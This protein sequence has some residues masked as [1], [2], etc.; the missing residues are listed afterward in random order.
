MSANFDTIIKANLLVLFAALGTISCDQKDRPADSPR[1]SSAR[2]ELSILTWSDYLVPEVV[3]RFES[4]SG[5]TVRVTEV[6]NSERLIQV[7]A[8]KPGS[9]DVIIADNDSVSKLKELSLI[10]SINHELVPEFERIAPEFRNLWFDPKNQFSVPYLWGATGIAYRKSAVPGGIDSWGALWDPKLK[11]HVAI[12][13]E[14]VDMYYIRLL[15]DGVDPGEAGVGDF[16]SARKSLADF[17]SGMQGR[18]TDYMTALDLLEAGRMDVV[19]TYGGD[20]AQRM[21][22]NPDI[23][24]VIPKEGSLLWLDSFVISRDS[25]NRRLAHQF[26]NFMSRPDIAGISSNELKFA[27]PNLAAKEL[28]DPALSGDPNLYPDRKLLEKCWFINFSAGN[29]QVVE[30]EVVKLFEELRSRGVSIG[31][32]EVAAHQGLEP[33]VSE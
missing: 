11:G 8:E 16:E 9:F 4:E 14:P 12:I 10:A 20:A 24:F 17:F 27:S 29:R 3:E 23:D 18:M 25:P 19:V 33:H 7:Q 6:E 5:A 26:L 22:G 2:T 15:A 32:E 28:I 1:E 21:C 30:Q 13:D 31:V